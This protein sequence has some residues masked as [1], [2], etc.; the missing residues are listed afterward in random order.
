MN[1]FDSCEENIFSK[2]PASTRIDSFADYARSRSKSVKSNSK[3]KEKRTLNYK[4]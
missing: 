2:L 4:T 1:P 3:K